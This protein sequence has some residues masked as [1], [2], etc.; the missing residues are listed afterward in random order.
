MPIEVISSNFEAGKLDAA[1]MW[2]PHAR[3]QVEL[4]NARYVA[5]ATP[6]KGGE[7]ATFSLMRQE[8]IEK[9]PQAAAGWIKAEIEA[10][11][12]MVKYPKETAEI[13]EKE[14]TGY[15][16][17]TAWAALYEV[18]PPEIGGDPVNASGKMAFDKDVLGLMKSGYAFLFKLKVIESPDMPAT[19]INDGPLKQAFKEMGLTAPVGEI[20]GMPRSAFR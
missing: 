4:G 12:F 5:T 11:Q 20:R 14:L 9:H 8:F 7:V 3:R 16:T 6:W 10:I 1:V 18:N 15:P 2:E 17:K 19:A 13:L